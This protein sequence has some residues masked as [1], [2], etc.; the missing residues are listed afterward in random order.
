MLFT[1][2]LFNDVFRIREA[3]SDL[4]DNAPY[5][6]RYGESFPRTN[7]YEKDNTI[8]VRALVPGLKAE[9]ISL[10]IKDNQLAIEGEKKPACE[11]NARIRCEREHGRFSRVI[12]LPADVQRDNINASLADGVLTITLTKS[13]DAKPKKIEIN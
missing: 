3:L 5:A 12:S 13:E 2:S 4:F 9:D 6:W 1:N 7:V 10:E 11:G 8:E